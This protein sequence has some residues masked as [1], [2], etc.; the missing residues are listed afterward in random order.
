MITKNPL[1]TLISIRSILRRNQAGGRFAHQMKL[2]FLRIKPSDF[3]CKVSRPLILGCVLSLS[4]CTSVKFDVAEGDSAKVAYVQGN[5]VV[6][7]KNK[8][9]VFVSF[10]PEAFP[11]NQRGCLNVT[12]ANSSKSLLNFG[13][14]NITVSCDG[15]ALKTF[16]Y[17]TLKREIQQRAAA[18]AIAMGMAGAMQAAAASMPATTT[19]Y[20]TSYGYGNFSGTANPAYGYN[21]WRYSGNFN[22]FGTYSATS[23][24]YN[25]AATVSAQAAVNANTLQQMN[26]ITANRNASLADLESMLRTTTIPPGAAY[27]GNIVFKLPPTPGKIP[28]EILVTVRTPV[29]EHQIRVA[30]L[31]R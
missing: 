26:M 25:P 9:T 2:S 15:K 11:A 24:T 10:S 7:S 5:P 16:T 14:E 30:Y 17:E 19:T 21:P 1:P 4:A 22:S 31:K 27:G 29:D 12:L 6:P 18:A 23:T 28:K 13:P 3:P 8:T 20:G